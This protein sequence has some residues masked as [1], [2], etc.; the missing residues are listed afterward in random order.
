MANK[1]DLIDKINNQLKYVDFYTDDVVDKTVKLPEGMKRTMQARPL[2]RGYSFAKFYH[3]RGRL[4]IKD[5]LF[6]AAEVVVPGSL[7]EKDLQYI[8]ERA[9]ALPSGIEA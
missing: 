2:G 9:D 6:G 8:L 5:R 3:A 4:L 1:A 7:T